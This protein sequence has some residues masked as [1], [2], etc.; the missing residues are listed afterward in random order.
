[1]DM[2]MRMTPQAR[3]PPTIGRLVTMEA[4]RAYT[5]T[6]IS[7]NPIIWGSLAHTNTQ[8]KQKKEE[9]KEANEKGLKDSRLEG[10]NNKWPKGMYTHTHTCRLHL[11]PQK[12]NQYI[13]MY[14]NDTKSNY[15]FSNVVLVV[16]AA[17]VYS[18]LLFRICCCCCCL[19]TTVVVFPFMLFVFALTT[20]KMLSAI[21]A[22]FEQVKPPHMIYVCLFLLDAKETA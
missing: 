9:R 16:V 18:L 3:I 7:R 22:F 17:A 2:H 20:Y 12:E 4:A 6:P 10:S 19:C 11:A 13:F 1:M 15:S 8:A 5:P 21:S 14:R